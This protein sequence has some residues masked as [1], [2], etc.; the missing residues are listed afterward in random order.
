[1]SKSIVPGHT[2][3]SLGED[4]KVTIGGGLTDVRSFA[5][6]SAE[7]YIISGGVIT[8][9]QGHVR[10]DTESAAPNDDLDTINGGESGEI[11]YVLSTNSAR[12]I[13]I[14]NGV[15]NIFLKHQTDN[16]PFSFASPQ[17]SGAT[18]YAGGGFY[19]WSTTE[20]ILNQGALT[21]A[22][23][24]SNVSYA[25]H[26]SV[27]A[28]GDGVKASG[29][30]VITVTGTS[31]DDEGNRDTGGSEVI[32]ADATLGTFGTN[33]YAETTLKW[34]GTITFTLS[35]SGGGNFNCSFNYG[36]SKYEDFANQGFTVTGI[37]CVGEAGAADT[38]FNMRLL[39]HNSADWTYAASGFVPGAIA[40]KASEL[41]NMNTDHDT[42]I[43]L[44]NGEPFAWKR[45]D[46]NQDVSGDNGEGLVIEITTGAAKAVESMSGIIWAHTA[47]TFSYLADTK[48]HL[49]FMKHGSNWLEL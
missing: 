14:R 1:M 32:V 44:A 3:P 21:Q 12:N 19:D 5:F 41:A 31:I 22:F 40:G 39:Y 30:L 8:I 37:Q 36:L 33:A 20:A 4:G 23:G 9:N 6:N 16:H 46:L 17:G 18:R 43:N 48:Q 29:D 7:T 35:S 34:I 26:A 27:V 49:V 15:G 11:I 42:E 24:T 47:P 2:N 10:V 25:A 38:G 13:R 28:K 45:T